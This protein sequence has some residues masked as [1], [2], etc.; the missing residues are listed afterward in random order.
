M[1][2]IVTKIIKLME[3]NGVNAH[4]LE[5]AAQL[6]NATIKNWKNGR[7][8]PSLEAVVKIADYFNVSV[9]S[10]IGETYS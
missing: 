3:V 1:N 5:Q 10:L 4:Q 2:E 6:A 9:D 7:N 8:K